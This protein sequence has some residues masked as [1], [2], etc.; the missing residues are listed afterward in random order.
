MSKISFRAA[1]L[2]TLSIAVFNYLPAMA[3][4][5]ANAVF[6]NETETI[7]LKPA[8]ETVSGEVSATETKTN[9]N[10]AFSNEK[11]KNAVDNIESAQVDLREQLASCKTK[12][13]MKTEELNIKKTELSVLKKEYK[14][15]QKKMKNTEKMKKMINN[16][17]N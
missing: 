6:G 13:D 5:G 3:D 10:N 12:V 16:N 8:T 17:I 4:N 14:S 11:F 7:N 2:A 1:F 9:P 15:L